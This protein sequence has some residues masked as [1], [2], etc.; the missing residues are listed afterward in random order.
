[1][2][3]VLKEVAL[4]LQSCVKKHDIICRMGGDEFTIAIGNQI[5]AEAAAETSVRVAE[6]ILKELGRPYVLNDREVFLSGSIGVA[7]YP[8]DAST[9]TELLKNA[10]MAMYH[11]K[12]TG[13]N[14]VQF[15]TQA[16][17]Q[18]AV[19]LLELEN[20]LRHALVRNELEVYY[21]PQY[22]ASNGR[23][24]AAEAL[25]R[26]NHP[27]KGIIP[28]VVFIPIIEDTGLIVPVG[29][30][31]LEQACTQFMQWQSEG[32]GLSRIAVNVSVR[33][34]KQDEF[35]DNVRDVIARTGILPCQL[36]LE[37]TESI[38]IDDLDHTLNVLR[39]LGDMGVRTAIDDFGTGYS[40]LNYLK[41]FPVDV[42]KI[43]RSFIQNL[44]D[45]KDDAQITR[46]IIAMAH[47][48]GLGVIA[49]G[50]ETQAQLDFLNQANCEEVQGY[51]FNKPLR[52][53]EFAEKMRQ[54]NQA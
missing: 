26:W 30:W 7:I 47:N 49:E 9:A 21:Q 29:L 40:S 51:L 22:S 18:K 3:L 42:L 39:S 17:N 43:D 44:P 8:H 2:D 36:E 25:L 24:V 27:S 50:V 45:N 46:T 12:E 31:V 13:R 54:A 37:L 16:M 32:F 15:Y 11:S 4:R 48:L 53:V 28:P 35:L 38:L 23:A 10:D 41:Q 34:F 14:K 5:S 6:R 20:D 19:E 33:Q 52:A 1:G